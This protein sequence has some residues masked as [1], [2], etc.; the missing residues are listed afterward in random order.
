MFVTL[1][2]FKLLDPLM[3]AEGTYLFWKKPKKT[4]TFFNPETEPDPKPSPTEIRRIFVVPRIICS[5][6]KKSLHKIRRSNSMVYTI[7]STRLRSHGKSAIYTRRD[8][9]ST[10]G[11]P[12]GCPM[13][14]PTM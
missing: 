10:M 4:T 1:K 6:N 2:V 3:T 12:M 5:K 11:Y 8:L 13:A 7:V 14:Y 9:L